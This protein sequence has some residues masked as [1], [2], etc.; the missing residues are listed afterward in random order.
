MIR[1]HHVLGVAAAVSVVALTTP[2][3]AQSSGVDLTHLP[4]GKTVTAPTVGGLWTC[5]TSFNGGGAQTAGPWFNGDGTYDKT[6]KY[7]VD[8]DVDWPNA[9]LTVKKQGT[10]LVISTNDLPTDHTTGTFPVASTDDAY[11]VDRNPNAITEQSLSFELPLHPKR[12]AQASCVAGEV[13]ILK[14][15]VVVFDAVDAGG[16]DAVADEGQDLCLIHV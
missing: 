12:A 5:Q 14:S 7:T 16:R 4:I 1:L 10:K 2:S 13:G 3:G 8:G 9:K 11:Q 6:K 15:G